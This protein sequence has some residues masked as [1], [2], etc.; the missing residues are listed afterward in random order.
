[1]MECAIE[2]GKQAGSGHCFQKCQKLKF[3][4]AETKG[5]LD[6]CQKETEKDEEGWGG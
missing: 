1:M 4:T 2:E 3:P 5:K 6:N